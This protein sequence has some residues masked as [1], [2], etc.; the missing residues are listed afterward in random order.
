MKN[1]NQTSFEFMEDIIP[2]ESNN[3]TAKENLFLSKEEKIKL[4]DT[5]I[6]LTNS[7]G[8]GRDFKTGTLEFNKQV[9]KNSFP[10]KWKEIEGQSAKHNQKNSIYHDVNYVKFQKII[11]EYIE[12]IKNNQI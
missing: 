7:D 8:T 2:I 9:I 11:K 12:K 3:D 1:Q 5:I 6:Q 10:E 4:I